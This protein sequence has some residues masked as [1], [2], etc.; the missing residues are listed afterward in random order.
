MP[1][2]GIGPRTLQKIITGAAL[3]GKPTMVLIEDICSGKV[4][5]TFGLGTKKTGLKA[6]V[7]LVQ[8][9]RE[10][11]AKV[12]FGMLSA[13]RSRVIAKAPQSYLSEG[14]DSDQHD[15][16]ALADFSVP[17]SAERR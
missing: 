10:R 15:Q 17:R 8:G 1:K 11:I 14:H 5:D 9:V 12:S 16:V 13:T 2:R 7:D 4:K 3:A 6:M